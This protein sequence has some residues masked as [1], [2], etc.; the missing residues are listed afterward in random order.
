M[1]GDFGSALERD[2]ALAATDYVGNQEYTPPGIGS[3]PF[4]YT[5]KSDMA[6]VGLV[7]YNMLFLPSHTSPE[8][9]DRIPP[10]QFL[11]GLRGMS[12][13]SAYVNR[14][15]LTHSCSLLSITQRVVSI[16][17]CFANSS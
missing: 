14:F 1:L 13:S 5:E 11:P 16:L 7:L 9:E 12:F 17:H 10:S 3:G 8:S 15:S 2:A 4:H 6:G